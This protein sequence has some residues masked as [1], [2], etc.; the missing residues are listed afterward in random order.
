MASPEGTSGR[1]KELK[2]LISLR[3]RLAAAILAAVLFGAT[4]PHG[5][6]L[7]TLK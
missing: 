5:I 7:P 2:H 1:V 6:T 3:H 4:S